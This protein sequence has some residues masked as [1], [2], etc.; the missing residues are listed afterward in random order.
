MVLPFLGYVPHG[1][2]VCSWNFRES[3]INRARALRTWW[4]NWGRNLTSPPAEFQ[5]K[6]PRNAKNWAFEGNNSGAIAFSRL[7][8]FDSAP[9][10]LGT[11]S[12]CCCSCK[13]WRK[14]RVKL[15]SLSWWPWVPPFYV[16][17]AVSKV[18]LNGPGNGMGKKSNW[19]GS[20]SLK[21]RF[22]FG[23]L[24]DRVVEM[25]PFP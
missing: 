22:R 21:F 16:Q 10:L 23:Y 6:P 20:W 7:R 8:V 18:L 2:R 24:L 3:L 14:H 19:K 15:A 12:P 13:S 11:L 5:S 9:N 1:Q 25:A 4:R 17:F